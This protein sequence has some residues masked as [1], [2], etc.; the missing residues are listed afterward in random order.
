[1]AVDVGINSADDLAEFT[2]NAT[3][4]G[5]ATGMA[6]ESLFLALFAC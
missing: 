1:M 6:P 3:K 2:A 4:L 5:F